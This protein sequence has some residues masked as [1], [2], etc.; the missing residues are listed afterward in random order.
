[1]GEVAAELGIR[2]PTL[3]GLVNPL[4]RQGL[5][6]RRRDPV[7]WRVVL[8]GLSPAGQDVYRTVH[9]SAR[10][11]ISRLVAALSASDQEALARVLTGLEETLRAAEA[12]AT[13]A[14]EVRGVERA[15]EVRV[16]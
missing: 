9:A 8:L 6:T 14:P 12:E 13:A 2:P 16:G 4:H 3:T 7:A 10:L 5:V 11:R 1:M 15:R